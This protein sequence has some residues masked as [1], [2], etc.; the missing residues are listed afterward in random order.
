[1]AR[2]RKVE[3]AREAR[4]LAQDAVREFITGN[5]TD[6]EKIM[7]SLRDFLNSLYA[8]E[9]KDITEQANPTS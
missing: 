8:G 7:E 5:E 2:T 9:T 4:Q 6:A 1:M 3:H